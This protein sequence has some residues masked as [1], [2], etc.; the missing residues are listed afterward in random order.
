MSALWQP[1]PGWQPLP[2]GVGGARVWQAER[3]GGPVVVK[4]LDAPVADDPVE[5]AR[6]DHPAYWRREAEVA[7]DGALSTTHG[8]RAVGV[9]AVEEDESGTTLVLERVAQAPATGLSTARALGIFAGNNLTPAPWWCRSQLGVRLEQVAARG[10]WPT[11]ARTSLADVADRLWERRRHH[12]DAV[13]ALPQV[14]T[15]GDPTPDNLRG[16]D[17]ERMIGI[18]WSCFGAAAA[19]ADLGYLVLSSRED[20]DVLL[21][22]YVDGL[23]TGGV[24][25]GPDQARLAASVMA[26][27]T[28]CTRAEWALARLA[29]AQGALAGKYRHPSVAPYIRSLQRLLP[30]VE[31]LV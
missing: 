10:G 29:A 8:I 13:A 28:A 5:N 31:T 3:A 16:R 18:D 26:T 17:G 4:R 21:E 11:L 15:H 25:V 6:P 14:P 19:G 7:L 23:A 1:E 9:L 27:Y 30:Q 12:L 22:A 2:G 24:A 20:F